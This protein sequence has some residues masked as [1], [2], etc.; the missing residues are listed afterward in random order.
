MKFRRCLKN[1]FAVI[2]KQG[3]TDDG[4]G[5]IQRLWQ[6]A[7]EHFQEVARLVQRDE[8]GNSCGYW[9]AMSDPAREFKPWENGF[10]TGLYLAGVE[11]AA[12]AEPPTGWVKWVI[13]GYEYVC[14]ENEAATTFT[15]TL[16][17]LKE[18]G[19]QLVGAV[20]DFN[21]PQTGKGYMFFPIRKL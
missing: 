12:S 8:N 17:Y 13:P 15:E 2:G 3:S 21:C 14:V 5:F 9:G 19:L 16:D 4:V 11:C 10:T 7:T 1:S 6:E 20:H 18:N